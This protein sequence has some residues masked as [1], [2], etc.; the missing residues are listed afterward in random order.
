LPEPGPTLAEQATGHV[1]RSIVIFPPEYLPPP[2]AVMF[3]PYLQA[4]TVG[5][6][7]V[8]PLWTFIVPKASVLIIKDLDLYAT[9]TTGA[10]LLNF[11]LLVNGAPYGDYGN[12][13]LFGGVAAVNSRSFNDL[14]FR[15]SE[16]VTVTMQV[17]NN[18]G[19]AYQ[20][21]AGA[22]GWYYSRIVAEFYKANLGVSF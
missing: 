11:Q 21:A 7:T 1:P 15:F 9:N 5:A 17:V 2:E 19:A 4:N 8:T 20:V 3:Q 12:I 10:T 18:D 13:A 6:G 22:Q 14:T 16:G